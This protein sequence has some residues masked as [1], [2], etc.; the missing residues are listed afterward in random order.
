MNSRRSW[1]PAL[2]V[3]ALLWACASAAAAAPVHPSLPDEGIGGFDGACGVAVD[4]EGNVYVASADEGI[5]I[6]SPERVP[7]ASIPNPNEPC[8]L[9]VDPGGNLYAAE[10]ATGDVVTYAPDA[11]PFAGVPVHGDPVTV[12]AS[13]EARGIAVDPFDGRLYV[14]KGNHLDL[15]NPDDSLGINESQRLLISEGS[16]GFVGFEFRGETEYVYSDFTTEELQETL[17]SLSTIGPGNVSVTQTSS[18]WSDRSYAVTFL[19]P[20]GNTDVPMISVDDFGF[21]VDPDSGQ[22]EGSAGF[23]PLVEGFDGHIR[24]QAEGG[25][26]LLEQATGVAVYTDPGGKVEHHHLFVADSAG[27]APDRV[28][29]LGGVD[30]RELAPRGTVA[31]AAGE[32]LDFGAGGAPLAAD[33]GT[34][35]PAEQACTAGHF[36]VPGPGRKTVY[37]F[38]A[39]GQLFAT[40]RLE[41]GPR[42]G[43]PQRIAVAVDRSG[44][45]TD[46]RLYV[47]GGDPAGARV[48]AFGPVAPP[49]RDDRPD[50]SLA[51]PSACGVAVDAYGNRYVGGA[52][53]IRV[54]PPSGDLPLTTIAGLESP[55]DLAVDSAGHVYALEGDLSAKGGG[56]AV[57]FTP[58]SFP[59]GAGT[60][61]DGPTVVANASTLGDKN[62]SLR[63]IALDPVDDHLFVNSRYR[64]TELDS[65]ENGSAVLNPSLEHGDTPYVLWILAVNDKGDLA[66]SGIDR[67]LFVVNGEG[68]VH[69]ARS[70]RILTRIDGHGSPGGLF[71][72]LVDARVTVDPASGHLLVFRPERGAWEEYEPS[73]TFVGEFGAFG[74]SAAPSAIAVDDG[75]FSPNRGTVFFA[76]DDASPEGPDLTA[77]DSLAYPQPPPPSP[78]LPGE[79]G[80]GAN[81]GSGPSLTTPVGGPR[82]VTGKPRRCPAGKRRVVRRGKVLCLKKRAPSGRGPGRLGP[83]RPVFRGLPSG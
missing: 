26:D 13:G 50:L 18:E 5:R 2:V 31:G 73:G 51:L 81:E 82:P 30:F 80:G 14:A 83:A 56:E 6:F 68:I 17:E 4:A 25:E 67:S 71:G 74:P 39:G 40:L 76:H 36:F 78:P 62:T 44:G 45:T 12:D 43:D 53:E 63:A 15:Y 58:A 59:P 60:V 38:E 1:G 29:L 22:E 34:C 77:F 66:V 11:F 9:A 69:A 32:V 41:G 16:G 75:P 61:Y 37:E 28:H 52:S 7:L 54:Y 70:G 10:R 79:A 57:Y 46:G 42:D 49:H 24:P 64:T 48:L 8:D 47:T 3:V 33:Q 72:P 55:C 20:L 65:A 35:P 19:G 23:I 27:V 21:Q